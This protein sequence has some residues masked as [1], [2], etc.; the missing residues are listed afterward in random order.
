MQE[1]RSE[2]YD[3]SEERLQLWQLHRPSSSQRDETLE[4]HSVDDSY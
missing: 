4:C 2:G 3:T 1:R